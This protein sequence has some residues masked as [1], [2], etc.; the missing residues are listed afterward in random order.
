[1]KAAIITFHA[2]QNCGAFLQAYAL[3]TYL[4]DS[5]AIPADILNYQTEKQKQLSADFLPMNSASNL[6]KNLNAAFHAA[7]LK[8]REAEYKSMQEKYLHLTEPLLSFQSFKEMYDKYDLFISGSDQIW[9][10]TLNGFSAGGQ[11]PY[12]LKDCH[13][14]KI[15][16]AV[17]LGPKDTPALRSAL[18]QNIKSMKEYAAISV[19][20]SLAKDILKD[21]TDQQI[22]T[23]L[24]PVFLLGKEAYKP[25][26]N[27]WLTPKEKYILLYSVNYPV[28]ILKAAAKLA[29]KTK[30]PVLVPYAGRRAILCHRYKF[31][32]LYNAG[33]GCFLDLLYNAEYVF[34]DSFHGTAFA[35]LFEKKFLCYR[36]S[37]DG[38]L[39][40][41]DR[42]QTLLDIAHLSHHYLDKWDELPC[43]P[44]SLSGE[45][46]NKEIAAAKKWLQHAVSINPSAEFTTG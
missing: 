25:L 46:V 11:E 44:D 22:Q 4:C 34:T 2:P 19:R 14:R 9:N 1:M 33:P 15:A 8:E 43:E 7:K 37:Q 28:G 41:D 13:K 17:S 36:Q 20:E 29:S 39:D 31:K 23:V 6:V 42:I 18:E 5:M 16:Y 45:E 40:K 10:G 21:Y 35:I 12:F 30:L 38:N 27:H 32:V 24:D 26:F 3:Q